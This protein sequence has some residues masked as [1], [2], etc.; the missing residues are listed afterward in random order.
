VTTAASLVLTLLAWVLSYCTGALFFSS[1]KKSVNLLDVPILSALGCL[2]LG[3]C[4]VFSLAFDV[5]PQGVL[6][7]L[8]GIATLNL[9]AKRRRLLRFNTPDIKLPE[10]PFVFLAFLCFGGL[11]LV[12]SIRM[13]LGSEFSSVF[14]NMDSPLRLAHAHS[15]FNSKSYPPE[16]IYVSGTHHAYHYGAPASVAALKFLTNLPMH[17]AM[18]WA[19]CPLMVLGIFAAVYKAVTT[20]VENRAWRVS[21]LFLFAPFVMLWSGTFELLGDPGAT[22][23]VMTASIFDTSVYNP[24]SYGNGVWDASVLAGFFLL[25]LT[26]Q[27]CSAES[28]GRSAWQIYLVLVL[29]V[30]NKMDMTV[31]V[32]VMLFLAIWFRYPSYSITRKGFLSLVAIC[33]PLLLFS[34]FDYGEGKSEMK[35]AELRTWLEVV[36]TLSLSGFWKKYYLADVFMVATITTVLGISW[37]FRDRNSAYRVTFGLMLSSAMLMTYVVP[38]IIYVPKTGSQF[39]LAIWVGVPFALA[40]LIGVKRSPEAMVFKLLTVPFLIFSVFVQLNKLHHGLI[41]ITNPQQVEEYAEVEQLGEALS[42][43]PVHF[44]EQNDR[45]RAYIRYVEFYPDLKQAY[46]KQEGILSRAEW[47]RRHYERFGKRESRRIPDINRSLVVTN[48][49][50]FV[51]FPDSQIAIPAML[52]HQTYGTHQ[53]LFPGPAGYNVEASRRI[54]LQQSILSGNSLLRYDDQADEISRVA[55]RLG[56]THLLLKKNW[57]SKDTKT[58]M[59]RLPLRMTFENEKYVVFA[60]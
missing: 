18:F 24:A 45:D 19:F 20:L 54:D 22:L 53:R 59:A 35:M 5:S 47:G 3:A 4:W 48:D 56:W 33:L 6:F 17:K 21:T 30:L 57:N 23:K 28:I 1:K 40:A 34:I 37:L 36:E 38:H 7:L 14:F 50:N 55:Y 39:L 16:S 26:I 27:I 9:I 60:F 8:L 29:I 11:T 43:I 42:H 32:Y 44:K 13:G 51:R 41:A 52:G 15:I 46:L 12:A 58:L 25:M 2:V 49:F 10:V 31:V